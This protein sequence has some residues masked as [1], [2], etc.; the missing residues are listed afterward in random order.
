MPKSRT[1]TR[2]NKKME[3]L[4]SLKNVYG[5]KDLTPFEAVLHIRQEQ[6]RRKRCGHEM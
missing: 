2:N 4:L 1:K 5:F 6:E 3:Q